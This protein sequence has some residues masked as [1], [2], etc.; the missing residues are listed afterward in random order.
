VTLLSFIRQ[1]GTEL[2]RIRCISSWIERDYRLKQ[3]LGFG[4]AVM[5]RGWEVLRA[6]LRHRVAGFAE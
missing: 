6:G 1:L 3:A 2:P 5:T 4:R